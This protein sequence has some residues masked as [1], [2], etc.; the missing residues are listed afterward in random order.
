MTSVKSNIIL[1]PKSHNILFQEPA[2]EMIV[3]CDKW[4]GKK[5]NK[6]N[7]K[8]NT[9]TSFYIRRLVGTCDQWSPLDNRPSAAQQH[10][11]DSYP[12]K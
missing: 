12:S 5:N 7:D 3:F 4:L 6:N 9:P 11:L 2:D 8:I 1:P 10:L